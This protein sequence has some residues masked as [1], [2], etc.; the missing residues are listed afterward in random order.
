MQ[1]EPRPIIVNAH[2]IVSV[3]PRAEGGGYP[4]ALSDGENATLAAEALGGN[5]PMVGDYVIVS[6]GLR[7]VPAAEFEAFYEATDAPFGSAA[8]I[9]IASAQDIMDNLPTPAGVP[10]P[11]VDPKPD[12]SKTENANKPKGASTRQTAAE[13]PADTE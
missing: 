1:Y 12:A 13:K 9:P 10:V 8:G 4:V 5:I 3:G 11:V 7:L 2:Q 6:P